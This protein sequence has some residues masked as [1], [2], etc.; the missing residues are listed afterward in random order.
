MK[1]DLTLGGECMMQDADDVFLS[2]TLE[3]YMVINQCHSNKF[4][5][6]IN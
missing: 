3:T 5:K 1:R 2:C 4:N 6:T